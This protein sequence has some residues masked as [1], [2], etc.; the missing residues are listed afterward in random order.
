MAHHTPSEDALSVS[1]ALHSCFAA[2]FSCIR[3]FRLA[4]RAYPVV[5]LAA[6]HGA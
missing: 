6:N 3:I 5:A 1:Q 4:S 2:A